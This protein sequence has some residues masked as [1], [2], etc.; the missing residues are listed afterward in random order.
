MLKNLFL[1]NIY[2][3]G[4]IVGFNYLST[5][6]AL[7]I[8]TRNLDLT[9][10]SLI[11]S[12]MVISHILSTIAGM[13]ASYFAISF[14]G[15]EKNNDILGQKVSKMIFTR[16]YF[17]LIIGVIFLIYCSFFDF[18]EKL[19]I[20]GAVLYI[21]FANLV[22]M[23]FFQAINDPSKLVVPNFISRIF[24]VIA[25]YFFI[26]NNNYYLLIYMQAL[27]F[28]ITAFF[29]HIYAL[30]I[31]KYNFINISE[32]F[33]TFFS[34]FGYCI[35]NLLT[36]SFHSL[37]IFGV[38]K[39]NSAELA[40]FNLLD[41]FYRGVFTLNSFIQENLSS[42]FIA[43]QVNNRFFYLLSV[44]IFIIIS[45]IFSIFFYEDIFLLIYT[46]KFTGILDSFF[47]LLNTVF[48]YSI[49]SVFLYPVLG[50]NKSFTFVNKINNFFGFMSILLI[51]ITILIM[52]LS[53]IQIC[54]VILFL[55]I[56][57]FISIVI[58][59]KP[60]VIIESILRNSK[61]KKP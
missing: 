21:I 47:I 38:D 42:L 61:L 23:W 60:S 53:L 10:F 36:Y 25:V 24:F 31:I 20:Y 12:V 45:Y 56:F 14:F 28:F 7:A 11:T 35:S 34:M 29:G 3:R 18:Y 54:Y 49:E 37:W 16:L 59:I 57:K 27:S 50:I 30:R 52:P 9:N 1:R 2:A 51:I 43:K 26:N 6:F 22:N 41:F 17:A 46:D 40:M 39:S 58:F 19:I 13:G 55:T 4:L 5:F 15:N 44:S 8:L 33:E 32:F 48:I